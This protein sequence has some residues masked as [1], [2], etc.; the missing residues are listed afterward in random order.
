MNLALLI[1]G[2]IF[3]VLLISITDTRRWMG[4]QID[5][6][7]TVIISF[8][9]AIG[10]LLAE[11]LGF[12]IIAIRKYSIIVF[13]T[14]I[15]VLFL[16]TTALVFHRPDL[17]AFSFV[18]ALS[19]VLV[20][21]SPAG[22]ILKLFRINK[23]VIPSLLKTFVAWTAFIGFLGLM[24]PEIL[25]WHVLM[26]AALVGFIALAVTA[27]TNVIDK[28]IYPL[29][30]AM[31]IWSAY[32]YFFPDDQ[33]AT[34]RWTSSWFKVKNTTMDRA[35]IENETD[36]ATTY[37][38]LLKNVTVLYT[39][40][41]DTILNDAM[42]MDTLKKGTKVKIVSHKQEIKV[43][44]GQ[45]F[46]QIQLA[47]KNGSFVRGEKYYTEA[48]NVQLA[49]PR[50]LLPKDEALL[51]KGNKTEPVAP[52]EDVVIIGP[53]VHT[54]PMNAG[55][56]SKKIIVNGRYCANSDKGDRFGLYYPNSNKTV[57]AWL[58]GYLP[59]DNTFFLK[60]YRNQIV[61]IKVT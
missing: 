9:P 19:L 22:I 48:E 61:T 26:G 35:S 23:A 15:V 60:S 55:Q 50:D 24:C 38:L 28:I 40:S 30:L 21:W 44:D 58:P 34:V 1:I 43:I 56:T 10:N 33:R 29:V 20:V 57:E 59:E 2:A 51:Q 53:G 32:G 8:I 47:H 7:I 18:L 5:A 12:T 27:K 16:I 13:W 31:C 3:L 17:T 25:T 54:F 42:L 49:T 4:R 11:A 39:C 41:N 37:G 52:A 6:L 36:A 14:G 45:G 46:I